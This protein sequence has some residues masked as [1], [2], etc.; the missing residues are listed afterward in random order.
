[1]SG[2]VYAGAIRYF[3]D[4]SRNTISAVLDGQSEWVRAGSKFV[5]DHWS[6]LAQMAK[7]VTTITVHK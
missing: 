4:E 5:P 1:M 3:I 2:L 7:D 6:F